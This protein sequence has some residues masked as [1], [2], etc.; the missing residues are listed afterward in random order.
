LH[1]PVF[2]IIAVLLPVVTITSQPT[3]AHVKRIASIPETLLGRWAPNADA[4]NGESAVVL[5]A[6]TYTSSQATCDFIEIS[7]TPG[8]H[9]PIYSARLRC[10]QPGQT[11]PTLSNLILRS[12]DSNRVSIGTD[13][14]SLKTYQKCNASPPNTH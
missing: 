4:C 12:E 11:R 3:L 10:T 1:R 7:E 9:G 2:M 6:K 5:S 14:D 8:P 13:F